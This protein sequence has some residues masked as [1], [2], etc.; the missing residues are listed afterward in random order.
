MIPKHHLN[1]LVTI[2]FTSANILLNRIFDQYFENCVTVR[3]NSPA[4]YPQG[5]QAL[6]YTSISIT[7]TLSISVDQSGRIS[8]SLTLY[9]LCPA[10]HYSIMVCGLVYG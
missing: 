6:Q 4:H 2:T 9:T 1:H 10:G 8:L 5:N 7:V 3:L